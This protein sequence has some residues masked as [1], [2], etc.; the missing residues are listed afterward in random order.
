MT[1]SHAECNSRNSS[2]SICIAASR[3]SVPIDFEMSTI[4]TSSS[5][6]SVDNEQATIMVV[7]L[8]IFMVLLIAALSNLMMRRSPLGESWAGMLNGLNRRRFR[9]T[10]ENRMFS[11]TQSDVMTMSNGQSN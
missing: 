8:V 2:Y 3:I 9:R 6:A 5:Y 11:T 4:E 10:A 1:S 7:A